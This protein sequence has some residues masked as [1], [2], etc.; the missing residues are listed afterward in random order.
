MSS[1][2]EEESVVSPLVFLKWRSKEFLAIT[3]LLAEP[4]NL[5]YMHL[6]VGGETSSVVV[7]VV[8]PGTTMTRVEKVLVE[9]AV[10][11]VVVVVLTMSQRHTTVH[12]KR[13][14]ETCSSGKLALKLYGMYVAIRIYVFS[15]AG[16]ATNPLNTNS[17]AAATAT[18]TTLLIPSKPA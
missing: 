2:E 15:L 8:L 17:F 14:R 18:A 13:H 7:V 6:V 10:V 11:V 16:F 3:S 4:K 9:V 1:E 5:L 12:T